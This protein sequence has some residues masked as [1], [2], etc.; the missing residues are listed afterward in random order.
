MVMKLLKWGGFAV[1]AS[2]VVLVIVRMFVLDAKEKTAEQVAKIHATILTLDD[3]M[4]K[5]VPPDPGAEADKTV[6]GI[7][8]NENGIRDDVELAIF[9]EY[10]NSAKTRA[11][12]LQYALALQM[13]MIQPIVNMETVTAVAEKT[14]GG[15][16]CIGEITSRKD[17]IKF[18]EIGNELHT[19]VESRQLNTQERKKTQEDFYSSNLGSY[20]LSSDCDI[21]I[22]A[23][24]N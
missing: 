12:L 14:S 16:Y 11:V 22:T 24:P 13:E 1:L 10:P 23:L 4:G 6:Q 2:F 18:I 8:A 19:F 9:K 15:Y 20:E 7:D 21:D 3:V 17:M 5:N